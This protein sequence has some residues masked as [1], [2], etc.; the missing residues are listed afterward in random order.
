MR[1]LLGAVVLI[2]VIS[3]PFILLGEQRT[4]VWT[5]ELVERS[6]AGLVVALVSLLAADV[7]LPVP[8]SW[9]ATL[10]GASFGFWGGLGVN[11]LG[12]NLG[13][14]LG[15]S[16]GR[17]AGRVG[18][19]RLLGEET[20]ERLAKSFD[21][22][23]IWSIPL[24]RGVPV[25]AEASLIVAGSLRLSPARYWVACFSSNLGVAAVYAWAGAMALDG[26]SWLWVF[27]GSTLLPGVLWLVAHL[28]RP[29]VE[30]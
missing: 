6:G 18:A 19:R 7:V 8:S 9:V 4:L 17:R 5:K 13:A 22:F 25:L 21:R 26:T 3:L 20:L 10:S 29:K 28:R 12:L 16:L 27:L 15:Y 11:W 1:P 14:L 24:F 30:S 23:G 2:S